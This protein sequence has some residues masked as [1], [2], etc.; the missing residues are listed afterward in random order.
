MKEVPRPRLREDGKTR[1]GA[2]DAAN[3][4][5]GQGVADGPLWGPSLTIRRW[6]VIQRE[7]VT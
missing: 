1:P 2:T 3:E 5:I 6:K 4:R 7:T